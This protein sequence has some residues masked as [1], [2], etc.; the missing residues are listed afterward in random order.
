MATIEGIIS[1]IE[2]DKKSYEK[3]LK[4][5][6]DIELIAYYESRIDTYNELLDKIGA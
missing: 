4:L 1:V 5:T 2:Y 3:A 6:T